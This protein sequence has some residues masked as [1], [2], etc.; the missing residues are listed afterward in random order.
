MEELLDISEIDLFHRPEIT[1]LVDGKPMVFLCDTG[2][3]RTVIKETRGLEESKS[4]IRVRSANGHTRLNYLSKPVIITMDGNDKWA[5]IQVVLAPNCP[6]NLLGR[7]VLTLLGLGIFPTR[8]G[9]ME[10]RQCL[11]SEILVSHSADQPHYC[12]TLEI[13]QGPGNIPQEL[14]K[15]ANDR[16]MPGTDDVGPDQ[17]HI[18][19][20]FKQTPGP[21]HPFDKAFRGI[22]PQRITIQYL[23]WKDKTSFCDALVSDK[24]HQLMQMHRCPHISITKDPNAEWKDLNS[25]MCDIKHARDWKDTGNKGESYSCNTGYFRQLLCW[26]TD[27]TPTTRLIDTP[28]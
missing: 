28:E 12:W 22:G 2:A 4:T 9:F 7:E 10:V 5:E 13:P 20:R 8:K 11:D 14:L 15:L 3:D 1:L 24:V 21:D 16:V 23:Y 6:H 25:R 27:S 17:L 26:T 19:V 18:L